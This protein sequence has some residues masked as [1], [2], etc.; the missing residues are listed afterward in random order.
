[1]P[2]PFAKKL[3]SIAEGQ[4]TQFHMIDEGDSTLCKQIKKVA[5]SAVFVSWCVK[6]AEAT[7]AEFKFA[8]AHSR[9]VHE[10]IQNELNGTGV[11]RGRQIADHA[12]DVGD[13][14]HANRNGAKFTY[15]FAK[16]H[17]QY[18]SHSAIVVE[19]GSDSVGRYALTIGGNE[20]DSIRRKIVRLTTT[21]HIKQRDENPFICV[22]QN[23]K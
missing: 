5:W 20:S 12:P 1:M 22:I 4:H 13:I 2:T 23:L 6:K 17:K 18:E 16:T 11:F 7:A 9:F 15:D 3:A 8:A 21:G 19:V 14:I 10:A